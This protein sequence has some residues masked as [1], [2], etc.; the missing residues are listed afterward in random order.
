MDCCH[1]LKEIKPREG[2]QN[3]LPMKLVGGGECFEEGVPGKWS[4]TGL[5]T[6]LW[7]MVTG[8]EY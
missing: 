2:L 7:H 6:K 5:R 8:S 1:F 3:D 4:I